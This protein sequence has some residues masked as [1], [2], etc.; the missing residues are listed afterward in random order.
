MLQKLPIR[1]SKNAIGCEVDQL[2]LNTEEKLAG[3][4][5]VLWKD[6]RIEIFPNE[7]H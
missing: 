5:G 2:V 6:L 4:E 3:R 1:N 7:R